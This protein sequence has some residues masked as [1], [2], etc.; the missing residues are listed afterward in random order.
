MSNLK[1]NKRYKDLIMEDQAAYL[2]DLSMDYPEDN[3]TSQ[4]VKIVYNTDEKIVFDENFPYLDESPK[5]KKD[6]FICYFTLRLL[7]QWVN[8]VRYGVRFENRSVMRR[9]RKEL[10]NGGISLCNHV[11]RWDAVSVLKVLGNRSTWIPILGSHLMGTEKWFMRSIG[12]IPVPDNPKGARA[13]YAAFDEIDRRKE[14]IH[15]FPEAR[16]WRYYV[17]IRPFQ[18]GA[19]AMAYK[20]N[21]PIIPMA[22]SYRKRT[23]I[24]KLFD[25]PEEPLLTI[26]VCEP[27]FPNLNAPRKDEI[28]RMRNEAHAAMVKAA[29]IKVNT[30][31][32]SMD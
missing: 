29:G 13:F 22:I 24:Y 11:H 20:Y 32:A 28:E 12:G 8:I 17:P 31:P 26:R 9:Y 15:F 4:L 21:R 14:W 5:A 25:K 19:F 1:E 16:S 10:K 23:G 2:P 18:K 27:I 6:R 30:W 7:A 3:P